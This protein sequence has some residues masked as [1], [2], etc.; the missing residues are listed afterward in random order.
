MVLNFHNDKRRILSSGQQR[1]NDGTTLK[2]ANK[3]NE[4]TW[5]CDLER[6]ATKGAAQCGSF[7]SANRGV[8]QEL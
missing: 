3:M 5:D 2:A 6:Q 7:T 4:L 1:N 8:N